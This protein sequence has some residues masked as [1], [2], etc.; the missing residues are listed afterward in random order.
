MSSRWFQIINVKPGK[1]WKDSYGQHQNYALALRGIGNPVR[2]SLAEPVVKEPKAGDRIYGQLTEEQG[3]DSRIF[4]NLKLES[5]PA[6]YERQQ[7]IHTQVALKLAVEVWVAQGSNPAAYDNI[8]TE[9]IHF[10]RMIEEIKE[11][12]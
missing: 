5:V 4:Y 7:G 2:L 10:A 6:D 1:S 12:L 9:A 11:E 3:P 8:K